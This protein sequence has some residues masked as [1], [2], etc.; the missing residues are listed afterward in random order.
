MIIITTTNLAQTYKFIPRVKTQSISLELTDDITG[1]VFTSKADALI[2]YQGD[3]TIITT[4]LEN[5]NGKTLNE[6]TFY[7]LRVLNTALSGTIYKDKVFCTDQPINQAL[8]QE[9][10]INKDVYQEEQTIEND[11]IIL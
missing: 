3:Y 2:S 5:V 1:E 11:Y 6:A 7:T 9:Y 4:E 10:D 8:R